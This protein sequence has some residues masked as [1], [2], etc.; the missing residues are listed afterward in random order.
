[1]KSKYLQYHEHGLPLAAAVAG[2]ALWGFSYLFTRLALDHAAP[3]VVLSLRFLIA[4]AVMNIPVLLGRARI[5]LRGKPWRPILLL[6]VLEP[7]YF[8]FESYG[9]LYTN[10][11][12]AGVVL[13]VVPVVSILLAAAFLREFP[14]RRQVLFC[15]LPII[16]VILITVSGSSLGIIRPLGVILLAGSCLASAGYRTANRKSAEAFSSFERTYFVLLACTVVFTLSALRSVGW[17]PAALL[18]PLAIPG[19]A[20][21]V[22]T[23]SLLCSIG[24]NLLVNYAAGRMPVAKLSVCGTVTTVCSAFAGVVFLGEPMTWMSLTGAVFIIAGVRQVTKEV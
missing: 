12:F 16:G 23:L 21:P 6:S 5:S 3:D 10:A 20:L 1:M 22:L 19:A 24:A 9:I 2:H 18:A 13:A 4:F 17:A 15:L 14:S 8:Y 7:L 11:T